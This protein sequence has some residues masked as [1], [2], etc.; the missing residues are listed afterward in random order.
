MPKR[1]SGTTQA[2]VG[3]EPLVSISLLVLFFT[4]AAPPFSAVALQF[5]DQTFRF[6]I[7]T[8][9]TRRAGTRAMPQK[10]TFK[11]PLQQH[12]S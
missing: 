10:A 8:P 3:P 9:T 2:T 4:V 1:K 12:F 5:Y 11:P 7:M 6:D